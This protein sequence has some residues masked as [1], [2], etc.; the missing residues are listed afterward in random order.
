MTPIVQCFFENLPT[1]KTWDVSHYSELIKVSFKPGILVLLQGTALPPTTTNLC[2]TLHHT[3]ENCRTFPNLCFK[4][5]LGCF[6]ILYIDVLSP[7][8]FHSSNIFCYSLLSSSRYKI[9]LHFALFSN[10]IYVVS[11]SYNFSF[12]RWLPSV[13]FKLLLVVWFFR[14]TLRS[15]PK[16]EA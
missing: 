7:I 9:I 5:W 15:P 14:L 4:F 2:S 13:S 12:Y 6:N 16:S 1:M 10:F 11:S 8:I 3:S